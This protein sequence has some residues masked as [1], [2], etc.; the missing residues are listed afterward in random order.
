MG[1]GSKHGVQGNSDT[2]DTDKIPTL[3]LSTSTLTLA[4]S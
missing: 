3:T 2:S 1:C 4:E